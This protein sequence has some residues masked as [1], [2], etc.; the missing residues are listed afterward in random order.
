MTGNGKKVLLERDGDVALLTLNDPDT[1]NALAE[2]MLGDLL[3][4]IHRLRRETD[5]PR[6]LMITG[7]GRGFCS[8]GS[9]AM[10]DEGGA[11]GPITHI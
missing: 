10:M 4:A 5:K 2:Q 6:C 1:L 3:D 7:A 9:V 11:D 8:G